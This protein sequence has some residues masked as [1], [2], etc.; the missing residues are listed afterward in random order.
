LIDDPKSPLL[1]L[2]FLPP[3]PYFSTLAQSKEGIYLEACENYQ[4]QTYRNR[5]DLLSAQGIETFS[6]PIVKGRSRQA[7]INT[8]IDWSVDWSRRLWLTIQTLYNK[9]PWFEHFEEELKQATYHKEDLL[10]NYNLN[11]L[12]T[13]LEILSIKTTI[14]HTKT[15]Q[16]EHSY[17][18]V[19]YRETFGGRKRPGIVYAI[20][21]QQVFS[22]EFAPNLSILDL[23]C[24]EGPLAKQIILNQKPIV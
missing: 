5:V 9:S 20:P 24:C 17:R 2:L 7:Y 6:I 12:T 14:R 11:W 19:D 1:P 10:F 22:Q 3:I 21:Y 16:K 13:C 23:I 8:K 15:Y 18:I 4:R